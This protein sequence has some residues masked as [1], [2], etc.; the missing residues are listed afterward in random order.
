VLGTCTTCHN[1]PNVGSRS[2]PAPQNIG[3][4]DSFRRPADMPLFTLAKKDTGEILRTTDP[5]R[6]LVTGRWKDVGRFK[7]PALRGLSA[8]SPYFHDGSAATLL[9]VIAFYETRF[10]FGMTPQQRLDMQAFL[11]SL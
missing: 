9:D 4:A 7:V 8:R 1:T 10:G 11:R 3:V 6:A 2:F 5:G